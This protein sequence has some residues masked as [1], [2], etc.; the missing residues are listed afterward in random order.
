MPTAVL[1]S[2][3]GTVDQVDDLPAFLANIRRG[4]PT[5]DAILAEVR[6]RFEAIGGSPLMRITLDQAAALSSRLGIPVRV[7]GRLWPPYAVDV[8][9]DLVRDGITT[10]ISL[11]LAPQSVDIYHADVRKAA[12]AHPEI[13]LRCAPAWGLEP[14]LIAAFAEVIDQGLARFS[15]PLRAKVPVILSAH[16]LPRRV[17]LAGDPYEREFLAMARAVGDDLS[18]RGN[19]V[20]VAF[21]SQGMDGGDWLGPDLAT[22]FATIAASGA[23][24][25][26][27]AA[28]GFVADHVETLYDLDIEAPTIAARAGIDHLGRAPSLNARPAFIDALECVVRRLL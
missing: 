27:I 13:E 20:H 6:R 16:S 5:P 18:S 3:H 14:R 24:S 11:P 28:I 10:L 15:E 9:T 17:V 1:L 26:L 2:C 12:L 22:V 19:P 7:A 25:A 23:R 8:A 4:R 21:Q